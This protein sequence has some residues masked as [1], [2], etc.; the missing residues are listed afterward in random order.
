KDAKSTPAASVARG[1]FG[2]MKKQGWPE[3]RWIA[4]GRPFNP[5]A[6]PKDGFERD[7]V[8]AL[9]KKEARFERVEGDRLRVATLIPLVDKSCQACH[10]RDRVGDPVGGLSYTVYLKK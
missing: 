9:K 6:A 1:L 2:A 4:T 10:T 3:T 8:A 7:A 5:D